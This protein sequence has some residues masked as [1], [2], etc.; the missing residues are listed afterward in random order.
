[1]LKKSVRA[2]Q[3][4][5]PRRI[6][7]ASCRKASQTRTPGLTRLVT[8]RPRIAPQAGAGGLLKKVIKQHRGEQRH[9]H[10]HHGADAVAAVC[11]A[12]GTRQRIKR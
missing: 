6:S 12:T 9:H 8:I 11:R 5:S 3:F 4:T 1:M 7:A 2:L 10:E